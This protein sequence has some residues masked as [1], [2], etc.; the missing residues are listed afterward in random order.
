[1]KDLGRKLPEV[2]I[3]IFAGIFLLAIGR[4]GGSAGIALFIVWL[5]VAVVTYRQGPVLG[6]VVAAAVAASLFFQPTLAVA[7]LFFLL[8][9]GVFV[10]EAV[11]QGMSAGRTLLLSLLLQLG[12]I[13]LT[14]SLF[15][16]IRYGPTGV[17]RAVA[18]FVQA[19]HAWEASTLQSFVAAGQLSLAP[20][21]V[22]TSQ[23]ALLKSEL[24]F[25]LPILPSLIV[26]MVTVNAA[27]GVLATRALATSF[28]GIVAPLAPFQTWSSPP[29]IGI[30]YL[31]GLAMTFLGPQGSLVLWLGVNTVFASQGALIA[32]GL[33]VVYYGGGKAGFSKPVR[34]I[35]SIFL[36]LIPSVTDVLAILGVVDVAMDMRKLQG[37]QS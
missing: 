16:L 27:L 20:K 18:A 10:G 23:T 26:V 25:F 4:A 21:S 30:V 29:W 37:Q 9:G 28:G 12:G 15:V 11:R 2:P 17:D 5:P 35:G 14:L 31:V 13:L 24:D 19:Y 1:M 3:A 22:V 6:S 8:I 32:H 34:V 36:M 33:A 7:A